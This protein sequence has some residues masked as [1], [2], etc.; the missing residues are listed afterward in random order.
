MKYRVEVGGFATV[1]RQR[2]LVIYADNEAEAEDKA[3][4]KFI[5]LQQAS[6]ADCDDGTINNIETL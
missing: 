3:I 1:Y 6:G 2:T 5:E 4:D